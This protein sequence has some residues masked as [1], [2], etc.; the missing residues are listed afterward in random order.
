MNHYLNPKYKNKFLVFVPLG[1]GRTD[2]GITHLLFLAVFMALNDY[3]K[4]FLVNKNS[5]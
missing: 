1:F 2:V 5:F 4:D 3:K